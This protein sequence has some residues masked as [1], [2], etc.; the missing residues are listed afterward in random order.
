MKVDFLSPAASEWHAFVQGEEH[1][2]YHLPSY[3]D[4]CARAESA[5]PCA[6]NIEDG[7]RRV[8]LPLI[9]RPLAGGVRD[10]TSPYGYPG[11][12]LTGTNEPAFLAEALALARDALAQRRI[13]SM[14]VRAHPLLGPP[15]SAECGTI[16]DHGC[17]VSIDLTL[18]LEE[19]WQRTSSAHRNEIRRGTRAGHLVFFDEDFRH[20]GAFARIY[21]ETMARVNAA[22]YYLF[23]D[24]YF[25]GLVEALGPRLHLCVVQIGGEVAGG[26]LFV[27]TGGLLQYHLSGSDARFQR[28]RPTKLMLNFVRTWAKDRGLRRLHLGGGIGGR[29]DSLYWFKAGFSTDRHAFRT[30]RVVCDETAYAELVRLTDPHANPRDCAGFFPLYRQRA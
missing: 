28:E 16:V 27:E 4:F 19:L 7:P 5:E 11:P 8:L 30:L 21:R 20:L 18:P 3:V 17:T 6:L 25:A 1:D 9:L 22:D 29:E 14:F 15:L 13:V 26:G 24:T 2:F 23:S 10:A 12:L